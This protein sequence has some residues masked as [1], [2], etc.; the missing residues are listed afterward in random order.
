MIAAVTDHNINK[1]VGDPLGPERSVPEQ[2]ARSP[3]GVDAHAPAHP[4]SSGEPVP[5]RSVSR[6]RP[7]AEI[8][9]LR[10]NPAPTQNRRDTSHN[11]HS[12]A[13]RNS[14]ARSPRFDPMPI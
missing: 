6:S 7:D 2:G 8:E 5:V 9:S 1:L 4:S 11:S 12:A 13:R 10:R 14:T 3:R